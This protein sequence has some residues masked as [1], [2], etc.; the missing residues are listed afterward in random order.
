MNRVCAICGQSLE[1]RYCCTYWDEE[2][3]I[4]GATICKTCYAKHILKYYPDSRGAEHIRD[5]SDEYGIEAGDETIDKG[6]TALVHRATLDKEIRQIGLFD[7]LE[8][9]CETPIKQGKAEG[10]RS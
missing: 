5:N 4:S 8:A 9:V 3:G 10:G 2:R 6:R 1:E 7:A